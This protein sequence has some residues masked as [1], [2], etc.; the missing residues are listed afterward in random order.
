MDADEGATRYGD[1][2][3][4]GL[5]GL[6]GDSL[7]DDDRRVLVTWRENLTLQDPRYGSKGL[8]ALAAYSMANDEVRSRLLNDLGGVL[9]E[10]P[11]LAAELPEDVTLRFFENTSDTLNVVLPPR[12]GETSRRPARL[13]DMLR[14]RTADLVVVGAYW[15]D[16]FDLF[17]DGFNLSGL[18]D[19]IGVGDTSLNDS[20]P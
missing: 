6:G 12:A 4:R 5:A 14:S 16:D 11:A 1:D 2:G 3:P 13:R 20:S 9:E 17:S 10:A 18:K 8:F 15:Q 7:N 19:A